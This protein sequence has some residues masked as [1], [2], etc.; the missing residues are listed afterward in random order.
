LS[1]CFKSKIEDEIIE[2]GN[3]KV[4]MRL[5]LA[6]DMKESPITGKKTFKNVKEELGKNKKSG[7]DSMGKA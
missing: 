7:A 6:E 5:T 3:K 4:G 2:S 1:S